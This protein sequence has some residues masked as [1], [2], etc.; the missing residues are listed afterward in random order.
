MIP[1][2]AQVTEWGNPR[3]LIPTMTGKM[4]YELWL[5]AEVTRW[6]DKWRD[7]WVQANSEGQLALF[8]FS[9]DQLPVEGDDPK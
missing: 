1:S 6:K 5:Q 7:A 2:I 4:H 3:E 8:T 9:T